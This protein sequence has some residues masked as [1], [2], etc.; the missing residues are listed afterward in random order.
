MRPGPPQL[1]GGSPLTGTLKRR[2][3]GR[4][5]RDLAAEISRPRDAHARRDID[6]RVCLAHDLFR[7]GLFDAGFRLDGKS[8][9]DFL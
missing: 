8:A 1:I 6:V 9:G 4:A 7:D 2:S 5:D 3:G